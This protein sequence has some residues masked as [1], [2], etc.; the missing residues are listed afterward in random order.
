MGAISRLVHSDLHRYVGRE[1]SISD[2]LKQLL[3]NRSFR[4]SFW[5]RMCGCRNTPLRWLSICIHRQLSNRYGIQIPRNVR[6]G[7]GLFIGHHMCIVVADSTTIG[8]NC[9][10]SQFTTI[11]SNKGQAA[12]IGDNVY[13]GPG[14]CIVEN[15]TLGNNATIGAGS[16]VVKDV[17][18]DSTVA[19]NPARVV[20]MK[21][22]GRFVNHR[23]TGAA[24]QNRQDGPLAA[25]NASLS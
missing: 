5:L 21:D 19:G 15:V 7:H 8:N 1:T 12:T 14:V 3:L 2:L 22:P 16:V 6:I 20:S 18:Q 11:G 17:P 25:T 24:I 13:I 23:W 9:N 10:L 4:Y